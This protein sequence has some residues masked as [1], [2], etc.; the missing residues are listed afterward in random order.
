MPG[1][2]SSR[3]L[4][5]SPKPAPLRYSE[6]IA[7]LRAAVR[8]EVIHS[9][10]Q[11]ARA[12]PASALGRVHLESDKVAR[13]SDSHKADDRVL[14]GGDEHLVPVRGRGGKR[15]RPPSDDGLAIE[16]VVTAAAETLA[17][18]GDPGINLDAANSGLIAGAG[19]TD[20][21]RGSVAH[22]SETTG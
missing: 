2:S 16:G 11:Q 17:E 8:A 4:P 5:A 10:G 6:R 7:H 15:L 1:P 9:R 12:V 20:E 3:V 21:T 22:G 14:D 18:G 19:G 13:G